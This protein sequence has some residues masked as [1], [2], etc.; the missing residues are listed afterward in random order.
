MKRRNFAIAVFVATLTACAAPQVAPT[1]SDALQGFRSVSVGVASVDSALEL[2]VDTM[3]FEVVAERSGSDGELARLWEIDADLIS[4]QVLLRSRD[5]EYGLLHLVQYAQQTPSVRSGAAVFDLVPKN[6]DVYTRNL[7][8][9]FD[10]MRADGYLFRNERYSE[11][12]APDGTLFREIHL[13]SHDDINVVLLEVPGKALPFTDAGFAG[14]GPLIYIVPDADAE[15]RFLR[16]VL[17]FDKLNDNILDG[18]EIER[19]VGL[20]PGAGLDVSIW[21]R[22]AVSF[23]GLEPIEYQGVQGDN[24]YPRAVP[25]ARGVL[26]VSYV[27]DDAQPLLARLTAHGVE[28]DDRGSGDTLIADGTPVAI[29]IAG[30]ADDRGLRT[31]RPL[32]LLCR[33]RT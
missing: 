32:S 4:R 23:G 28:F 25:G 9:I 22:A 13:P 3:G 11:V 15:K 29:S 31:A 24:R 19:M 6:L 27:I 5:N 21:G 7:P 17:Q 18:P 20:P 2:W 16:D 26:H 10:A 14:L 30:R 12:T 33:D 8:A 1:R